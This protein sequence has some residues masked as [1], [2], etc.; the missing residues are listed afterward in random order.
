MPTCVSHYRQFW[1][2]DVPV[3]VINM[4]CNFSIY[5]LIIAPMLYMI[6]P[7]VAERIEQFVK[8][9]GTFVTT[10][11]SG[12]ANE[13][14]LCFL[15]GFSGPLR[16]LPGIWAE[17]TDILYDDEKTI[18]EAV[19]PNPAG[20][21]GKYEAGLF[22]DIIHLSLFKTGSIILTCSGN[23][24]ENRNWFMLLPPGMKPT[25]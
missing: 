1:K 21:P 12:I 16:K 23:G 8:N 4:D 25:I 18:I 14:D 24:L 22:C 9:G 5:K 7:G 10:C 20:L 3:D 2:A 17:E 19:E 11:L 15:G 6:R 13:N